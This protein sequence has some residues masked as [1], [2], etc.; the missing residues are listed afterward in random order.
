[1][2]KVTEFCK[3]LS[4]RY[5]NICYTDVLSSPH[6]NFISVAIISMFHTPEAFFEPS[7]LG[8]L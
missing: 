4:S 5:Y 7:I 2:L 1:M 8:F 6:C 3:L